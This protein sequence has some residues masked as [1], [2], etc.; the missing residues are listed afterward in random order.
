[1]I[2]TMAQ[3]IEKLRECPLFEGLSPDELKIIAL[4]CRVVQSGPG[5][6]LLM[7][8]DESFEA[9]VIFQGRAEAYTVLKDGTEVVLGAFGESEIFGEF[10]ILG[11]IPR[12]ASVRTCTDFVGLVIEKEVFLK[13]LDQ[14]PRVSRKIMKI[15]IHRLLQTNRRY[16]QV[17]QKNRD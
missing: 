9:Y 16:L 11:D 3:K 2:L 4:T 7:E 1:M 15:L 10:A 5:Q 14:F 6:V 13:F 17:I 12:S 8:G